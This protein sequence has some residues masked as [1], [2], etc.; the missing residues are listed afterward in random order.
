MNNYIEESYCS[1]EVSKL[2]KEKGLVS[3]TLRGYTNK[4]KL[5]SEELWMMTCNAP[6]S[7]S[8][9]THTLAIEWI[10]VNFGIWIYTTGECFGEEWYP[11]FSVVSEEVWDDLDKRHSILSAHKKIRPIYF[12]SPQEAIEYA[13]LYAL[14][15]LI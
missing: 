13:L 2:L 12:S 3:E 8:R 15:N 9:P 10:R 6:Q 5:V 1:F 7:I 4:G 11:Q 14:T